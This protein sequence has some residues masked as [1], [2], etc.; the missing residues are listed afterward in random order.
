MQKMIRQTIRMD[1]NRNLEVYEVVC[2]N[3]SFRPTH[4]LNQSVKGKKSSQRAHDLLYF[5]QPLG[6]TVDIEGYMLISNLTYT[7]KYSYS[8]P[9]LEFPL[10][11]FHTTPYE[12]KLDDSL[13]HCHKKHPDSIYYIVS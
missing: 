5:R 4:P 12:W 1:D 7:I 6:H 9:L 2:E 11:F 10:F 3:P 13:C 8:I